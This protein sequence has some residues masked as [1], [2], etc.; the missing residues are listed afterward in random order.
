MIRELEAAAAEASGLGDRSLSRKLLTWAT[1]PSLIDEDENLTNA[2]GYIYQAGR[3]A[4]A[5]ENRHLA[6]LLRKVL[7]S[8]GKTRKAA[9]ID[10]DQI[11]KLFGIDTWDDVDERN[12]DYYW[13]NSRWAYDEAIKEGLTEEEAQ[14]KQYEAEGADRDEFYSSYKS[15]LLSAA[16]SE[17]EEMGLIFTALTKNSREFQIDPAKTWRVAA[18]NIRETVNGMGHFH[19]NDLREFLSSGPYT[20]REAVMQHLGYVARRAEVYG[21]YGAKYKFERAFP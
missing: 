20:P 3:E 5:Q 15:A 19:F 4:E 12:S 21:D 10:L 18:E 9:I 2:E 6:V 14:E 17:F 13:E 1:R 8:I 11:A 16:E 7:D